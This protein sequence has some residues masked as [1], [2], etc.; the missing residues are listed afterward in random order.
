MPTSPITKSPFGT[1]PA[2]E[3]VSRYTLDN[4]QGLVVQVIDFG[5]AL[6]SV[7]VP[8]RDGRPGEVTLGF[9][10]LEPYV[11]NP[12]YVGLM[13]GPFANRIGGASF[14]LDGVRHELEA[15]EGPNHLHGGSVGFSFRRWRAADASD[16]RGPALALSLEKPD[17]EANYPGNL[18]VRATWRLTDRNELRLEHEASTDRP[19]PVNLTTH[20]YWN[21]AGAD[22]GDVLDHELQVE[23]DEVLDVDEGLVPTGRFLEVADGPLD[24]GT[25]RSIRARFDDVIL[26]GDWKPGYDHAYRLRSS[27]TLQRAATVRDPGSGR[28]M[29][30]HTTC[31]G[32]MVYTGSYLDTP[33]G[34]GGKPFGPYSGLA[35][36]TQFFPD[37]VNRPH[38]PSTILAPGERYEHASMWRFDVSG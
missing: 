22:S 14:E 33:P 19:T 20:T 25:L 34:A 4:G 7:R 15:N 5:A 38:F 37:S 28:V 27:G 9:D 26:P 8:D 1:T 12:E 36:E 3:A 23:A 6:T 35:L 10:H 17:G 21:L 30:V 18:A 31:P 11:D 13:I 2:G 16:A 32:L 24:F 29:E